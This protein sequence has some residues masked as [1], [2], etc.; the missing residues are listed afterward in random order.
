MQKKIAIFILLTASSTLF[1][2]NPPKF[3]P[4]Q[5]QEMM[6]KA[7]EMQSCMKNIDQ[8][9]LKDLEQKGKALR[10]EVKNLCTAGEKS[11]AQS[12]ARAFAKQALGN[13]ALKDLK[14]CAEIMKDIVPQLS[15]AMEMY[16]SNNPKDH[17]CNLLN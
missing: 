10:S 7:Q 12:K 5:M 14:K 8:S 3:D 17:V 11:A 1:A 2:Q 16:E 15:K 13:P 9:V 6:L 4:Q